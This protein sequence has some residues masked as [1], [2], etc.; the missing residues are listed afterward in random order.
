M[1]KPINSLTIL[2]IPDMKTALHALKLM[3]VDAKGKGIRHKD[4]AIRVIIEELDKGL[5][6][7]TSSVKV[8][9]M[10]MTLDI[11]TILS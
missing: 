6:I 9:S 5:N 7:S 4:D 1:F 10:Y 8:S 2:Q 3:R 11:T